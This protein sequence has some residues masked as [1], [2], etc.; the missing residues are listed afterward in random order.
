MTAPPLTHVPLAGLSDGPLSEAVLS[1]AVTDLTDRE[2][3]VLLL[4]AQGLSNTEIRRRLQVVEATVKTHVSR[5]LTK[6]GL[7]DR[8]QVVIFAYESGLVRPGNAGAA[9]KPRQRPAANHRNAR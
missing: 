3:Q 2:L 8:S 9:L 7:R 1:R 5:I 6:L 4:I